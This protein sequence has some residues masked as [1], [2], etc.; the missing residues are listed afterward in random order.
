MSAT[1]TQNQSLLVDRFGRHHSYLRISVTDRCNLRCSYCMPNEGVAFMPREELL[2]YEE[3]IRVARVFVEAGVTKI[4]ITGG[5]PLIRKDLPILLEQLNALDGLETLAM[6]TNAVR[7]KGFAED[8]RKAGVSQLNISLDTFKPHRFLSISR[9][10]HL[11][12]VLDG[13]DKA[14]YV[15]FPSIKINMVV[16]AGFNEDEM[17]DFIEF[18]RFNPINVRFIEYMP[19]KDNNWSTGGVVSYAEMRQ[20]I[21]ERYELVPV[22]SGQSAVAKDF[23]IPGHQGRV[24]FITSM[25]ESFCDSCNRL[26]L[27]SDGNVKSC[28]FHPAE[29]QLRN[30]L[31]RGITDDNLKSLIHE[32]VML[33]E[34]AH[35]PMEELVKLDNRP[36]ITIGG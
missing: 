7:L 28:L 13:I 19:F 24:S 17:M 33:K 8:I 32:A 29:V 34:E 36:M 14:L 15:G 27:T 20:R 26:R 23:M 11:D 22:D 18:V 31:R 12:Q 6:T 1:L 3:I 2:T 16:I 35:D 9:R 25:T 10:N 5:E 4:R 21:E 30:H